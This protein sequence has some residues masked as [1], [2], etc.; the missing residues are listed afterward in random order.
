[1]KLYPLTKPQQSI[2]SMQQ[3]YGGS[4]ANITGSA[5][6]HN[7]VSI[8]D[9][10]DAL[11]KTL[12]EN[13]SLRIQVMIKDSIPM[14]YLVP[15]ESTVFEVRNFPAKS[16]FDAWI[17]NFAKAPFDIS[18]RLYK[19][20]IIKIGDNKVGY[21]LHLHHL[22]ADAW[23]LSFLPNCITK[24]LNSKPNNINSYLDYISTEQEYESSPRF[25]KDM[26]Y[27]TSCF[28]KCNEP[29]YL[30]DQ[31]AK[32]A[33]STRLSLSIHKED[34]NRMRNFCLKNKISPCA[35]FMNAL[36][37]Y[38]YR[39]KGSKEFFVGT[40]VL[41]RSGKREKETSGMFINT[42][43]L[44]LHIDNS[45]SSLENIKLN[46]ISFMNILRHQRY[47]YSDLLKSIREKH[48][49]ADRLYDV[50]LH[51]QNAS[52]AEAGVE[53][54][55]HFCGS[56]SESLNIHINDRQGEGVFNLDYDYQNDL[57]NS[58]EV[59][60]IHEHLLNLIMDMI[61]HPEKKPDELKLISDNEYHQVIHG[62]NV[63]DF[64]YPK[65]KF[66]HQFFEDNVLETPDA[67]ALIATDK[68]LT[69]IELNQFAN[70]IANV[71]I[72]K[73]IGADDVVAIFLPRKSYY[74]TAMLG[75][76]KS[77]GAYMPLDI[78]YPMDRVNFLLSDSGAKVLITTWEYESNLGAS[79]LSCDALY[80]E[81]MFEDENIDNPNLD[82]SESNL[83]CALHTSGSTGM[84]KTAGL[85][86]K[87]L[88]NYMIMAKPMFN[89]VETSLST[90]IVSFDIFLQETLLAL[91]CGIKVVFFSDQEINN[92]TLFEKKV[93]EYNKSY[94]FQTPTKLQNYVQNSLKKKFLFHISSLLV[95]GEVFSQEL[96]D[97]IGKHDG[98]INIYGPT[99]TTV[100]ATTSKLLPDSDNITIGR[101][102]AN[103]QIYILDK[104]FNPLPVGA[105]GELCISGDGVGRGYLN[106]PEL[107][108]EKFIPNPF[109]E[110]KRMYRTGDLALWREDGQL[111]YVGRMDNQVKIRGLRIELGEIEAAISKFA[112]VK[113]TVVIDIKDEK[114]RQY[115]CAY[116]VSDYDL[117]EKDLRIELA[118]TLPRYMIPHFF[119]KL[120]TIPSTGSGKTD[121]K[122]LPSPDFLQSQSITEY[123]APTTEQERSFI[124]LLE[125]VLGVS[126]IGMTDDFFDIG[127]DSLKV[128]E[129]TAVAQGEGFNFSAQ[130][131]FEH[132]TPAAILNKL[133]DKRRAAVQ[134]NKNDFIA[135]DR[136]LERNN[137]SAKYIPEEPLGDV[138]ITGATGWLGAHVLS[139]FLS[140]ESGIAYCLVMGSDLSESQKKL[141]KVLEHYFGSKYKDCARIVVLCRDIVEKIE[142]DKNFNTVI[143]CAA[144]VKHYGQYKLFHTVNVIGT[145]NVLNLAK[146][147]NARFVHI[148]TA[149]VS[150]NSFDQDPDFPAVVFDETKL[151]VEQ[152]LDNVYIRSKFESEVSVLNAKLEGFDSTIIRVGNLTNRYSDLVFQRN[153]NENAT[154]SRLKA[155]VEL[156]MYPEV[157][158]DFPLDFSPVCSTAR[159]ILAIA[160]HYCKE[161]SV[162]HVYHP[163]TVSFANFIDALSKNEIVLQPVSAEQFIN[164]VNETHNIKESF[165]HDL[166]KNGDFNYSGNI[167]LN[168][169]FTA[170][171]LKRCGF[172][173]PKINMDYLTRYVEYFRGLNYFKD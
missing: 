67:T 78:N 77:G 133:S 89:N 15:F 34:A 121:R 93:E 155:F 110:G 55:W 96:Y 138:L 151:Y 17:D 73:G 102:I 125:S 43:P 62:F 173:W 122:S 30:I 13:D 114:S 10:N 44:L 14:Q 49:F 6:F 72:K 127:G 94:I 28:D 130:D 75:I 148:S 2:W 41:N 92:Q 33:V 99:E 50:T 23:T 65:D 126:P 48:N 98:V 159:A 69:F 108:A 85:I 24:N 142:I 9:L 95:G 123:I 35:L 154:L 116:Y 105:V 83:F 128:I 103:T 53:A 124:R 137:K 166:N 18:G 163:E 86:H 45:K 120:D 167:T 139:E 132:S 90:T 5:F 153:Y 136:M 76:L 56:Q 135:I 29:V 25:Q 20:V 143:H 168:N 38:L 63:T 4:I 107:T 51:F 97:L 162:Y 61:K 57:F 109:I 129:L 88:C 11:N 115:L 12:E 170:L 39:I 16:N 3:Y 47:Q 82:I 36:A 91:A 149:S 152:P 87:N 112:G 71:L 54:K 26:D 37:T 169:D 106:R 117:N 118:K 172:E 171:H 156:G 100:C 46:L 19:I 84:P 131:V 22:I 113:Q 74:I 80:V 111:E 52:L 7:D 147:K 59:E 66:M 164:A 79:T 119:T 157:L 68:T 21:V 146:E 145:E 104:H 101:P 144:N 64:Y 31:Q 150:G 1:M 58:N 165:I 160:S 158:H 40:T 70:K 60:R 8:N 42:V 32:S 81:D 134:Y 141:Y 27:F 161:H 140:T